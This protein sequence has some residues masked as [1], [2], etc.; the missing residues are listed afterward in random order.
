LAPQ[1]KQAQDKTVLGTQLRQL[2]TESESAVLA[3]VQQ[4]RTG[5]SPERF[6]RLDTVIRS[7][8]VP[9]LRIVRGTAATRAP[10]GGN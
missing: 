8:V 3:A 5:M 2:E 10:S 7:H 4:L 9:R 1:F 6:A